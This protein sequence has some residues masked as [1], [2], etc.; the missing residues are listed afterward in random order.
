MVKLRYHLRKKSDGR[1][2]DDD[3]VKEGLLNNNNKQTPTSKKPKISTNISKL[4][5]FARK[6]TSSTTKSSSSSTFAEHIV[7]DEVVQSADN[8]YK[9]SPQESASPPSIKRQNKQS[10]AVVPLK[11]S[12]S[13][14]DDVVTSLS[15][16]V[17]DAINPNCRLPLDG[18]SE[19]D[20]NG[21]QQQPYDEV[22][23]SSGLPSCRLSFSESLDAVPD[24]NDVIVVPT[25]SSISKDTVEYEGLTFSSGESTASL[26]SISSEEGSAGRLRAP[27]I[28]KDRR[29]R[30][31]SVKGR[32]TKARK[33][34]K[35]STNLNSTTNWSSC[36]EIATFITQPLL[37]IFDTK[38][39]GCVRLSSVSNKEER[40][41]EEVN[42]INMYDYQI[43]NVIQH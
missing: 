24:F 33:S 6:K 39:C 4:L 38:Y 12:I 5:Q 11:K 8:K 20:S 2:L 42:G 27:R 13:W 40:D 26:S 36:F 16:P 34:G 35:G 1:R 32:G 25:R 15:S 23:A 17:A 22:P 41:E 30:R 14:V 29:A 28:A 3:T 37:D 43:V 21:Q 9:S 31:T 18:S 19:D 7:I 10:R